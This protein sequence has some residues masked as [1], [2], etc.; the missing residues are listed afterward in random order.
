MVLKHLIDELDQQR[1]HLFGWVPIGL[2]LGIG[3]YFHLKVEPSLSILLTFA[4]LGIAASLLVLKSA[5]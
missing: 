1:G 5:P 2:G 3:L 4:I